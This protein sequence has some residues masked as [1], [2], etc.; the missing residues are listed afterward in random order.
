MGHQLGQTHREARVEARE[1][2]AMLSDLM[3]TP[4]LPGLYTGALAVNDLRPPF[5]TFGFGTRRYRAEDGK[6]R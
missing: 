1:L 4:S 2:F 3:S 6:L 5:H